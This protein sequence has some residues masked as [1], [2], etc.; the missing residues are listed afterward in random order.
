MFLR[1]KPRYNILSEHPGN[2]SICTE[3][4]V[5]DAE[6]SWNGSVSY[7]APIIHSVSF[8][9]NRSMRITYETFVA[10]CDFAVFFVCDMK[11]NPL[12]H[13]RCPL[14]PI[15]HAREPPAQP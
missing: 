11:H 5:P 1:Q 14:R 9:T 3:S 15:F 4:W 12:T 6:L 10:Q 13:Q 8:Q 2:S 7:S